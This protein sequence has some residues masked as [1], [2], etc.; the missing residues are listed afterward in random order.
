MAVP[1][2]NHSNDASSLAAAPWWHPHPGTTLVIRG[3][4][5]LIGT[6]PVSGAKNAVLPLMVAALLTPHLVTLHNV[7]GSLDVA[8]LAN[9]L[10]RL[11]VGLSWHRNDTALSLTLCADRIQPGR[12]DGDLVGRM[13]ASVLLLG[14]LL[15]RCGEARL[16]MPGGDAIGLRG[17]DIH[18]AGLRAMGAAIDLSGGM[19]HAT[20]PH[21]LRGAEIALPQPSVGATENLL[22]AAVLATGE[23]V[24]CNAAREPEIADLARCLMAMGA[25]V[26]GVDSDTLTIQ[27]GRPLAGAVHTIMPDRIELGTIACAAA[28]TNG[29]VFLEHGRAGLLAAARPVLAAAGVELEERATGLIARRAASGLT[30]VDLQTRPYPGFATDL[31]APAMA[32][33]ATAS[34]ASAVTETIFEQRFRHVD[35][36]RKMGANIAVRGR[37]AW[38]RGVDRL[39]GARVTATDVRA[40]AALVLAGLGAAGDTVLDGLDHLDRG[41]DR[42]ADKLTACGA[43]IVRT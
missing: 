12:I 3:G 27:G 18:V 6:Y 41:Y 15:A 20:A 1:R 10:H 8:V 35:E 28:V 4:R 26:G 5:P 40:A 22:L 23:T 37:T 29:E 39:A 16:P 14:A 7:P 32:M 2:M 24:I 25:A 30:G 43:D 9:L 21:G 33:L 34:G 42:M 31:Q 36:L 13:R 38:V 19:I 11:G 17:I